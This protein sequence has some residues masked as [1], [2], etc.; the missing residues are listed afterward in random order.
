MQLVGD[1]ALLSRRE[2]LTARSKA[3]PQKMEVAHLITEFLAFYGTLRFITVFTTAPRA[4]GPYTEP[5]ESSLHPCNVLWHVDPLLGNDC[6][7]SNYTT[8]VSK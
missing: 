2:D 4:T 1:C 7:I 6:V 5:N 3:L 8:V